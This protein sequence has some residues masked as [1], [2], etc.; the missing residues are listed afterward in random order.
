MVREET[1]ECTMCHTTRQRE[2]TS[3][4]LALAKII[5]KSDRFVFFFFCVFGKVPQY[6]EEEPPH[7][8]EEKCEN[9]SAKFFFLFFCFLFRLMRRVKTFDE[10]AQRA[11]ETAPRKP[12]RRSV[13]EIRFSCFF[14]LC[15]CF[16]VQ[17]F[18]IRYSQSFV[19]H[20][21]VLLLLFGAFWALL[22]FLD[23]A[24][25]AAKALA[26]VPPLWGFIWLVYKRAHLGVSPVV[27]LAGWRV[28][29]VL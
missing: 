27:W 2:T 24:N 21:G 1:T 8:S 10:S 7:P 20:S 5:N 9:S 29:L 22:F 23:R 16:L 19:G 17:R 6:K 11:E 18:A 15:C 25:V 12:L 14:L 26:V 28:V 13:G 4:K 3:N